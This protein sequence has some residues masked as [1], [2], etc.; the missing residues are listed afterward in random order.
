MLVVL[1]LMSVMLLGALALA[2]L[3]EV[4]TLATGNMAYHEAA[5]QASEVGI[6]TGFAAVQAIANE[7]TSL[8]GWYWATEQAKDSN[9]LPTVDWSSAPQIAVGTMTVRYVAERA[10]TV[11]PVVYPLRQCLVKQIP[12]PKSRVAGTEELDPPNSKQYRITVRVTDQKGTQ[13]FVQS[14]VTKG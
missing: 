4:S 10:C 7:D 13:T 3:T 1:V 11:T 12:Q 8:A 5:M 9:G 2:R 14:L 6:N